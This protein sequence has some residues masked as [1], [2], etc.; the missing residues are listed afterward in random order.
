MF[1][2]FIN[3]KIWIDFEYGLFLKH[4]IN[5][6]LYSMLNVLQYFFAILIAPL[7]QCKQAAFQRGILISRVHVAKQILNKAANPRGKEN[8]SSAF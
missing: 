3:K 2:I 6:Q 4:K 1:C 5:L 8:A 7:F